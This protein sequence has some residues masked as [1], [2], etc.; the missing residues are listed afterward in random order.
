MF[1]KYSESLGI[2]DKGLHKYGA[3]L[4]WVLTIIASFIIGSVVWHFEKNKSKIP[5]G[6]SVFI[7]FL[8]I[9]IIGIFLHYVFCVKSRVSV[10]LGLV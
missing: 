7:C 6:F 8:F 9:Y 4:D 1:C 2:P 5:L 10:F 3:V